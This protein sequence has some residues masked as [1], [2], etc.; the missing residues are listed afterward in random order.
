[1]QVGDRNHRGISIDLYMGWSEEELGKER[2][3]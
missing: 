1:M 3:S 2:L